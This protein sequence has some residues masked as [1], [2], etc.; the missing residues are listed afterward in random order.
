[1]FFMHV[2]RIKSIKTLNKQLLLRYFYA[3]KEHKKHK[4]S[5]RQTS[6]QKE[7]RQPFYAHKT[8]KGKKIA[9]LT[10]YACAF[11]SFCAFCALYAFHAFCACEITLITL[12]TILLT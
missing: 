12:F 5:R 8:S 2:K 9:C 3:R 1:M 11:Y 10:F 7:T 4:T 6:E